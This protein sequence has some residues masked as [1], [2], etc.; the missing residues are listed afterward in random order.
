MGSCIC[1]LLYNLSEA[2]LASY[3][4]KRDSE[5]EAQMEHYITEI[6]IDGLRHLSDIVIS[7]NP[8]SRQ[9]LLITGKNGSGKTSLLMAVQKYLRAINEGNLRNLKNH[10]MPGLLST[11][12]RMKKAETESEKLVLCEERGGQGKRGQDSE[13]VRPIRRSPTDFT[14]RRFH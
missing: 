2:V 12:E 8:V 1:F 9:H 3:T 11:A 13:M 5:G 14:G 7:L 6:K 10:Y 4:W